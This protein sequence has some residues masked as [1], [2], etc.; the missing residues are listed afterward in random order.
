M[1]N[2]RIYASIFILTTV[3]SVYLAWKSTLTGSIFTRFAEP[4][5]IFQAGLT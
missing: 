2:S 3:V 5:A 4:S 1:L